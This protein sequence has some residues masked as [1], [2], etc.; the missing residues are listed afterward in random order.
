MV[1]LPTELKDDPLALALARELR[2]L[3][4]HGLTEEHCENTPRLRELVAG[5]S[6]GTKPYDMSP[7]AWT[8]QIIAQSLERTAV[9]PLKSL[10]LR[11]RCRL[12]K[13]GEDDPD[14]LAERRQLVAK[15][16]S[17][18]PSTLRRRELL[19]LTALL[20]ELGYKGLGPSARA[21]A[22][23]KRR[24]QHGDLS[25]KWHAL[26]QTTEQGVEKRNHEIVAISQRGDE[27]SIRNAE[28]S[29]DIRV[30]GYF[31]EGTLRWRDNTL[32]GE[33]W[34]VDLNATAHGTLYYIINPS[35]QFMEGIWVGTNMDY[36]LATGCCVLARDDETADRCFTRLLQKDRELYS[37]QMEGT[38]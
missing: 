12:F 19:L 29:P 34:S 3:M 2:W 27:L 1:Q 10:K 21:E 4:D 9:E 7:A 37:K 26:W 11:N 25:G 13:L 31:W 23:P 22:L 16:E 35:G 28:I 5:D 30:G 14:D 17:V 20:G 32:I 24:N 15:D 18:S 33:Y 8:A 38:A 6:A 36:A